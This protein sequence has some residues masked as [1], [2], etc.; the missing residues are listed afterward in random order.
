MVWFGK[1]GDEGGN[2]SMPN[3]FSDSFSEC[4]QTQKVGRQK[5]LRI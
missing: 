4:Y 3:N 2:S 1:K 5:L